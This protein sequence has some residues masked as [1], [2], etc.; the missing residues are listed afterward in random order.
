MKDE[1][2]ISVVNEIRAVVNG[3]L[4]NVPCEHR[5][6]ETIDKAVARA[7]HFVYTGA[8]QLLHTRRKS[9]AKEEVV[10]VE[11]VEIV[12]EIDAEDQPTDDTAIVQTKRK[13]KAPD[14]TWSA[15][16]LDIAAEMF[17]FHKH[18]MK[19]PLQK[20]KQ[21]TL[22][23]TLSSPA[24]NS[25]SSIA[26]KDD[27]AHVLC[28]KLRASALVASP[29]SI[30]VLN[31]NG[32]SDF[33]KFLISNKEAKPAQSHPCFQTI[34]RQVTAAIYDSPDDD[35]AVTLSSVVEKVA[36]EIFAALPDDWLAFTWDL[37]L[38]D[39]DFEAV[40]A[41]AIDLFATPMEMKSLLARRAKYAI[42]IFGAKA[43]ERE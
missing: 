4:A 3:V 13:K 26:G 33:S 19:K 15:L 10:V 41:D 38:L 31:S 9:K 27:E 6:A 20:K 18:M 22:N 37:T 35:E 16:S 29:S 30:C 1:P 25:D 12:A 43:R 11:E 39:M 2:V 36:E 42:R 24:K 23:Q 28:A 5:D 17:E 40:P 32:K 34:S 7:V 21:T 8:A 14:I